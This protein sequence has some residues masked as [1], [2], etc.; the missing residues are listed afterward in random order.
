MRNLKKSPICS[1]T[2]RCQRK[3]SLIHITKIDVPSRLPEDLKKTLEMIPADTHPMDVMRTGCSMLGN[4]EPE[5]D[6]D[7]QQ[8]A[9]DRLLATLPQSSA[10]GIATAMMVSVS[11]RTPVKQHWADI[12]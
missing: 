6:F 11:V 12:F 5:T 4:L 9:A 8:E 3:V 1:F 7:Q 2:V 10:I